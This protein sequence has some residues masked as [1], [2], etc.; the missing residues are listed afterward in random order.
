[1][2]VK[3]GYNALIRAV[4]PGLGARENNGLDAADSLLLVVRRHQG[5]FISLG[6]R[7]HAAL[8]HGGLTCRNL[9]QSLLHGVDAIG[10]GQQLFRLFSADDSGFI[11]LFPL[12]SIDLHPF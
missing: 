8:E 1:M 4:G 6:L 11:H 5:K 9:P 7:H 10:H 12:P 3:Q 2:A